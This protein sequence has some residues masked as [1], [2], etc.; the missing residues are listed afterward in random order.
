MSSLQLGGSAAA[1]LSSPD[2]AAAGEVDAAHAAAAAANAPGAAVAPAA[3]SEQPEQQQ[4]GQ[5]QQQQQEKTQQQRW[6]AAREP[7]RALPKLLASGLEWLDVAGGQPPTITWPTPTPDG[8]PRAPIVSWASP[9][10]SAPSPFAN[11]ASVPFDEL[12]AGSQTPRAGSAD[13][14]SPTAAASRPAPAA[15]SRSD[16]PHSPVW[17]SPSSD[18]LLANVSLA[19][20]G[21]QGMLQR[22][23]APTQD[24]SGAVQSAQPSGPAANQQNDTHQTD[25]VEEDAAQSPGAG[26][27]QQQQ[28]KL[29]A[30]QAATG[31]GAP[32]V[33][34]NSHNSKS[35]MATSDSVSSWQCPPLGSRGPTPTASPHY[36]PPASPPN[37]LPVSPKLAALAEAPGNPFD[38][39]APAMSADCDA[40]QAAELRAFSSAGARSTGSPGS[41][42]VDPDMQPQRPEGAPAAAASPQVGQGFDQSHAAPAG[43]CCHDV[44]PGAAP[45]TPPPNPFEDAA[46]R[47]APS[48]LP[49]SSRRDSPLD[50]QGRLEPPPNPSAA[51]PPKGP[52]PNPFAAPAAGPLLPALQVPPNP[53]AAAAAPGS[54][55]GAALDGWPQAGAAH[56][57]A[58]QPANPFEAGAGTTAAAR[59]ANPFEAGAGTTAAA[60]PANPFEADDD[61]SWPAPPAAARGPL[62]AS[63]T[64]ADEG[65]GTTVLVGQAGL[66]NTDREIML[67]H[68]LI[69]E[70]LNTGTMTGKHFMAAGMCGHDCLHMY[71]LIDV[72]AICRPADSQAQ[73]AGHAVLVTHKSAL[74]LQAA[75][76]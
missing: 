45:P 70:A 31:R 9:L 39:S 35:G 59:P 52:P 69:I 28:Q 30:W 5:Q 24:A 43:A 46:W 53:F 6:S 4:Q 56:T 48:P 57:A 13:A 71:Q 8:K 55:Q 25:R 21:E 23:N 22:A 34:A 19:A 29:A 64:V 40:P 67:P 51:A 18:A 63:G 73:Q 68:S 17:D 10:A 50:C 61:W 65:H 66:Y 36:T 20:Q 62:A 27:A 42:I 11:A 15:R 26:A 37:S 47:S 54:L 75:Q 72:A 38:G 14:A 58:A 76:S 44:T 74:H 1:A 7:G 60:R 49:A 33:R 3:N 2:K 16:V 32:A 12:V 41:S